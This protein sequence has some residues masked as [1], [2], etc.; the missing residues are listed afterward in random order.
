M[1]ININL[2][3]RIFQVRYFKI[4]TSPVSGYT[5]RTIDGKHILFLDYDMVSPEIIMVDVVNLFKEGLITHAYI[6]TT[7]ELKD[8][9]G[10]CGN[11]HIICLD[12]NTYYQILKIMEKTHCDNLHKDLAK[13]TRY[14]AWVLRFSGKGDRKEPKFVRFIHRKNNK[15]Q[16]QAHYKLIHLLYS[17]I[18]DK[19]FKFNFDGCNKALITNY[20]TSS[21]TKEDQIG[22]ARS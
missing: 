15:I 10:V 17:H 3:K 12:K 20:N 1:K 2:F 6:F 21:K 11:Y 5:S 13:K 22:I 4:P 7:Y 18:N 16:S 14:R 8:E 9:L 19:V